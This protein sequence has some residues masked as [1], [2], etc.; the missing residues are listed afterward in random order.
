LT[1]N[2]SQTATDTAIVTVLLGLR[3]LKLNCSNIRARYRFSIAFTSHDKSLLNPP[4]FAKAP[5]FFGEK[6]LRDAITFL[7]ANYF[8][9]VERS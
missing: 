1:L 8:S 7:C 2:I 5:D 6:P 3:R 4:F 9:L